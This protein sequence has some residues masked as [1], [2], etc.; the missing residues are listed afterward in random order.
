MGSDQAAGKRAGGVHYEKRGKSLSIHTSHTPSGKADG[1][2]L[3]YTCPGHEAIHWASPR[4]RPQH[5]YMKGKIKRKKEG[6]VLTDQLTESGFDPPWFSSIFRV[7]LS[8]VFMVL[9]VIFLL[10]SLVNLLMSWAWWDW[11][12]TW[13]TNRRPSVLWCC[14]LGHLTHKSSLKWPIMCREVVKPYYSIPYHI[15][16]VSTDMESQRFEKVKK[17]LV[18]RK[19]W[20]ASCELHDCC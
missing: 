12:L 18:V 6:V 4:G 17:S 7:P 20:H 9:C 8:L 14:L 11:P 13:L 2:T 15:Y 19:T 1:V 5:W 3:H 16:T 10:H